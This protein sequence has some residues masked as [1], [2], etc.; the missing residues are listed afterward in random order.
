ML[1][2]QT[3]ILT[4]LAILASHWNEMVGL[5]AGSEQPACCTEQQRRSDMTRS[6]GPN[7]TK[8]S[9]AAE[10]EASKHEDRT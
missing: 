2:D 1:V 9:H 10:G 8:L 3:T 6:H 4:R 5:I 7:E